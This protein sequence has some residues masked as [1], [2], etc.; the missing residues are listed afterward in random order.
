VPTKAWIDSI[1]SLLHGAEAL[2]KMQL[3]AIHKTQQRTAQLVNALSTTGNPA[4]AAAAMQAFAQDNLKSAVQYWSDYRAITQNA[5]MSLL[6]E[7]A[8]SAGADAADTA[9]GRATAA[10]SK[11][12]PAR[13]RK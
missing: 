8:A 3:E 12:R 10:K 6:E 4:E 7:A 5:E 2:R 9:T 11:R 1:E 13:T